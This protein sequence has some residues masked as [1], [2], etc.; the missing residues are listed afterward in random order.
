M[1]K[2][3]LLVFLGI[4]S[5]GC[6]AMGQVRGVLR[7]RVEDNI[8]A[9]S[10]A[11]KVVHTQEKE[12]EVTNLYAVPNA[13]A[14]VILTIFYGD[15]QQEAA[16]RM[17]VALDRL[18]VGPG[19]KRNDIGD[20]AYVVKGNAPD[21]GFEAIRFRKGNVYVQITGPSPAVAEDLAKRILR[22]IKLTTR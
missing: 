1:K 10:P 19:E 20:E 22:E 15:S 13:N 6:S 17:K 9:E 4:F 3:T 12:K 18:S 2:L 16:N 11:W 8:R 21:H 7:Q 5:F 14:Y